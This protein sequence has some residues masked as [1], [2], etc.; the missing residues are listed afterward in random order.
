MITSYDHTNCMIL[1]GHLD[2]CMRRDYSTYTIRWLLQNHSTS[3]HHY[4]HC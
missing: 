4:V 3:K 1:H 2:V